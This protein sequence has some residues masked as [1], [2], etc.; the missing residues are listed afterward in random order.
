MIIHHISENDFQ[1]ASYLLYTPFRKL[2]ICCFWKKIVYDREHVYVILI[3][4]CGHDNDEYASCLYVAALNFVWR[5]EKDGNECDSQ[6]LP[7][8]P[9][10]IPPSVKPEKADRPNRSIISRPGFGKTGRPI[11]LLSNHFRVSLKHP[12]EI[13]YQY[14]VGFPLAVILYFL[15]Q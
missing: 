13:F 6:P 2:T 8:P 12:D 10:V 9:P 14:T 3:I 5:M 11:S 1:N 7:A 15:G 4:T